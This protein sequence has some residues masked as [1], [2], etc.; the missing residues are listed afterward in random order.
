[1]P[2]LQ[3]IRAWVNN[4]GSVVA[5]LTVICLVLVIV[6]MR[7]Y[8]RQAKL[9]VPTK[10]FFYDESNGAVVV[11]PIDALPPL[12]NSEGKL[13]LVRAVYYTFGTDDEKQLAYLEKLADADRAAAESP[14]SDPNIIHIPPTMLVRRPEPGSPW[15]PEQSDAGMKVTGIL[16]ENYSKLGFRLVIPR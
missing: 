15:V 12:P 11:E 9:E 7:F 16:N 2:S 10:V 6:G 3:S 14:P 5:T 13:T 4:H 8:S 1:M